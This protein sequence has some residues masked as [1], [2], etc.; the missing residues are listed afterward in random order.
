MAKPVPLWVWI[1]L[2]VAITGM[3]SGGVWFGA[4][5]ETP[6]IM[7]ASWRLN[8][9]A[10]MQLPFF[11]YEWHRKTTAESKARFW[12][13]LKLLVLTGLVLGLHFAA[14]SISVNE[15]SL[16]HSL[17]FVCSSPLLMVGWAFVVFGY[18]RVR[19]GLVQAQPPTLLETMGTLLGF[20]AAALLAFSAGETDA[21]GEATATGENRRAAG[22]VAP[23]LRGDLWALLGA[24]T[25]VFYLKIG[26]AMRTFLPLFVYAFPVTASAGLS[27]LFA[28]VLLESDSTFLGFGPSSMLGF[29]GSWPRF[30][31]SFGAAMA[32]GILGHTGANLCLE[33]VSPLVISINLLFEPL[34]G[35]LLGY[36]VGLE[37]EP[38]LI[39]LFCG[40]LLMLSAVIVTLGDVKLSYSQRLWEKLN[41]W[42]P[43]CG[44]AAKKMGLLQ[45]Q[46]TQTPP[47]S[48]DATGAGHGGKEGK[49]LDDGG[50]FAGWHYHNPQQE[51]QLPRSRSHSSSV[52]SSSYAISTI[53]IDASLE[54]ARCPP[55]TTTT[56]AAPVAVAVDASTARSEADDKSLLSAADDDSSLSSSK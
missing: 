41:G 19:G 23:S 12:R 52:S 2:A 11:V 26:S 37:G 21:S 9:T 30:G 40:P 46:L 44:V 54:L 53:D 47:S 24:A 56:T 51:P 6:A 1:V 48:D 5:P 15:T 28:A 55:P 31:L 25:V 18:A 3:S 22:V 33:Y 49:P 14:W 42:F 16:S 4:L 35:S 36:A 39:T 27:C 20:F 45:P 34:L 7:K 29:L 32:A 13:A 38:D 50:D 8:L 17:L 10:V 43:A